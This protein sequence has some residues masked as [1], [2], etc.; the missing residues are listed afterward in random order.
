MRRHR[1]ESS[2]NTVHSFP[3]LPAGPS[4]GY[5]LRGVGCSKLRQVSLAMAAPLLHLYTDTSSKG[6]NGHARATFGTFT[7]NILMFAL[8]VSDFSLGGRADTDLVK[9]H[10]PN[11]VKR[12]PE[13]VLLR[14]KMSAFPCDCSLNIER[15]TA[16]A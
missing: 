9:T 16:Q 4:P 3:A 15:S 8:K 1:D 5:E 12:L 11:T 6:K 14:A 13:L 10:S 2:Q 7:H